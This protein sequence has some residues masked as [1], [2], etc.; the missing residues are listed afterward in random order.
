MQQLGNP[1]RHN[2]NPV[3]N[4]PVQLVLQ[5]P[6]GKPPTILYVGGELSSVPVKLVEHT[7]EG[8]FI[9]IAEV[10]PESLRVPSSYSISI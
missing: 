5:Q 10:L 9:K 6:I 7:Q 1:L 2:L 4:D 3:V 8:Q